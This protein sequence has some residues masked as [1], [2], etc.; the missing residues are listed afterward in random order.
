MENYG[1]HD[2]KVDIQSSGVLVA[3]DS[4]NSTSTPSTAVS[5]VGGK[6]RQSQTSPRNLQ[7]RISTQRSTPYLLGTEQNHRKSF[8]MTNSVL[9]RA[10]P[11]VQPR[12]D[13]IDST[14]TPVELTTRP[15]VL[16]LLML[17]KRSHT[18]GLVIPGWGIVNTGQTAQISSCLA[19][20]YEQGSNF[21]FCLTKSF[22][23]DIIFRSITCTAMASSAAATD[24]FTA[25]TAAAA[26][27]STASNAPHTHGPRLRRP[28]HA[29]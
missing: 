5:I 4:P 24:T 2:T 21:L 1:E 11:S 20:T 28:H 26:A 13:R 17:S 15:G 12:S 27:A 19:K 9:P 14:I 16:L 8:S 10:H 6:R 25:A 29:T 18:L 23:R 7:R 3:H 22:L